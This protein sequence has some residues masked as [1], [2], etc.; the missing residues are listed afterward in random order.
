M[1]S[2]NQVHFT[3]SVQSKKEVSY[4]SSCTNL[5]QIVLRNNKG[6]GSHHCQVSKQKQDNETS[7][8]SQKDP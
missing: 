8:M 3:I 4:N 5:E 6:V 2:H 1:R 7:E